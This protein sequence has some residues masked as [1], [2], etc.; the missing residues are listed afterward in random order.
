M[1]Q[2]CWQELRWAGQLLAAEPKAAWS[3]IHDVISDF[4]G[5]RGEEAESVRIFF[6]GLMA[7]LDYARREGVIERMLA[8]DDEDEP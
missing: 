7:N 4:E 3:V 2:R 1:M 5:V 6:D 8:G